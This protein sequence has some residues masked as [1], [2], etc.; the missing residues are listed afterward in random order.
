MRNKFS[1]SEPARL[2]VSRTTNLP[3]V[4]A[5]QTEPLWRRE[6]VP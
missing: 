5:E 3:V 4:N 1:A 2:R 6:P